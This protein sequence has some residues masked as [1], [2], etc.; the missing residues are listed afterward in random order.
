MSDKQQFDSVGQFK[1]LFR[2]NSVRTKEHTLHC[3]TLPLFQRDK[4]FLILCQ[5]QQQTLKN[6]LKWDVTESRANALF[7][8]KKYLRYEKWK[9]VPDPDSVHWRKPLFTE[10]QDSVGFSNHFKQ[11]MFTFSSKRPFAVKQMMTVL[12]RNM[13]A[14]IVCSKC[15]GR[16]L[17]TYS[18]NAGNTVA[19]SCYTSAKRLSS[20]FDLIGCL[21]LLVS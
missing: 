20:P 11:R 21:F 4:K 3:S 17:F 18:S 12:F 16:A 14:L 2:V 19:G 13:T 9:A 8:D 10:K 15:F 5:T 1:K 6:I 7:W